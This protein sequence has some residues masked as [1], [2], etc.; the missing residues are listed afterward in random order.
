MKHSWLNL[1]PFR[2]RVLVA[3]S[4]VATLAVSSLLVVR[5]RAAGIPTTN[6]LIYTGYLET[7]AGAP[8]EAAVSVA[9]GLWTAQTDGTKVCNA[10]A[11]AVTPVAGRFQIELPQEC[12]AAVAANTDLWLEP[13]IGGTALGR[14]KVGAAP[15]AV[16]AKHAVVA[17]SATAGGP[18]ADELAAVK[19]DVAALAALKTD[20]AALKARLD[21][22]LATTLTSYSGTQVIVD[23]TNW[24]WVGGTAAA[25]VAAGRHN[26]FA[27]SRIWARDSGC[28]ATCAE[29]TGVELAACWKVGTTLTPS[30]LS[31]LAEVP[32]GTLS[33]PATVSAPFDFANDTANVQL[34]LC[35]HRSSDANSQDAIFA[36][37][38]ATVISQAK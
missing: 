21:K 12:V 26:V 35:A 4:V 28:S 3:G 13:T 9:L 37:T 14:S 36:N 22:P 15:Y 38:S 5:A 20:V 25:T 2:R 1:T 16:E 34:G 19:A 27:T 7:P 17:D 24:T 33:L 6:P 30:P 8:V 32:R 29:Y 10:P 18:L 31:V 11:R 23:S